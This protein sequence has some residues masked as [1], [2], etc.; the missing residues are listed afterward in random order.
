M[1]KNRPDDIAPRRSYGRW[2]GEGLEPDID[3]CRL[4]CLHQAFGGCFIREQL[5][6]QNPI[7]QGKFLELIAKPGEMRTK[8]QKIALPDQVDLYRRVSLVSEKDLLRVR[9][10]VMASS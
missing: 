5:F 6:S 10:A 8:A 7:R 3:I 4:C 9:A 1:F 2:P